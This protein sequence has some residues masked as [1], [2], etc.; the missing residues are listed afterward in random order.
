MKNVGQLYPVPQR[1]WLRL[2][3]C[4]GLATAMSCT[5]GSTLQTSRSSK[6]VLATSHNDV[7]RFLEQATYGPTAADIAHL[8]QDLGGDL[9]AWID[10]QLTMPVSDYPTVCCD[11]SRADTT[12]AA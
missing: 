1:H 4:F 8:E 7:V 9:S 12:C 11:G 2:L 5:S 3:A 10:E 6:A